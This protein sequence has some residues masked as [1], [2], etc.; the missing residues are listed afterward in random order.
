[1]LEKLMKIIDATFDRARVVML[2]FVMILIAGALAYIDI[3]KES[4]PDVPIPIFYVS[5]F[6]EGIS[7]EDAERLLIRPMEKELQ[8]LE[9]LKEMRS[10]AGEG[11]ASV[12]VE[13]SAGFDS[14]QALLDVREKVDAA[15]TQLPPDTDEPSVTEVNVALFP[16]LSVALSGLVTERELVVIA[17]KLKDKLEALPGVLKADIGGDRE[18]MMEV[19]VDPSSIEAYD[20][21]FADITTLMHNNNKLVA[22]GALDSGAGRMVLK[23]PGVIE[24]IQDVLNLP[25]KVVGDTVVTFNDVL[26][27]RRVF[28]D[29]D[30][31]AR[32]AGKRAVVL[33][34]SKRLGANIIETISDVRNIVDQE[35]KGWPESIEITFMQDK[36]VQ[37]NDMLAGNPP[38]INAGL[39]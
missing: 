25:L 26:R 15:K 23:V 33:E 10:V 31:F 13:F 18:E 1:M 7:P 3:P 24:D 11:Y 22:A 20:I 8:S 9:G 5:M 19:V 14:D 29:P 32:I 30:S 38:I 34:I 4:E 6:Y 39:E 21:T 16:V 35:R 12:T 37:I 17:R 2:A 36:S 27:I 28:K